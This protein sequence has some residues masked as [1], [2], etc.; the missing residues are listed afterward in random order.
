M[1]DLNVV[2]SLIES[3]IW[4]HGKYQRSYIFIFRSNH[5]FVLHFVLSSLGTKILSSGIKI[6]SIKLIYD[7]KYES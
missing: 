6:A 1:M 7:R 5:N 3:E 4:N 2:E